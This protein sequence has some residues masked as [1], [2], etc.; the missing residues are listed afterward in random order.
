LQK[1]IPSPPVSVAVKQ[2][3]GNRIYVL[4]RVNRPGDFPLNNPLDVMQAISL[5]GGVT[6]YAAI[7][8]IVILRRQNGRQESHRFRYSDIARGRDLEQNI[9]LQSGDTVVVP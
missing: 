1:Y 8:D 5:A 4:G 7:N 6:P 2:I 3:G 9:Q